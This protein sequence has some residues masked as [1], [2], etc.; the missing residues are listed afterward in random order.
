MRP[1]LEWRP[2]QREPEERSGSYT[3]H[4]LFNT[5]DPVPR[6]LATCEPHPNGRWGVLRS[7]PHD[8]PYYVEPDLNAAKTHAELDTRAWLATLPEGTTAGV[9]LV[10]PSDLKPAARE[11]YCQVE[12]QGFS[13]TKPAGHKGHIHAAHGWEQGCIRSD[14]YVAW[15]DKVPDLLRP[16]VDVFDV[17][18]DVI[19]TVRLLRAA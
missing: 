4:L 3:D 6:L 10:S 11:P 1:T 16:Y 17:A 12:A 18:P 5:S 13:C 19:E 15:S 8:D 2:R 14:P 7:F 9:I